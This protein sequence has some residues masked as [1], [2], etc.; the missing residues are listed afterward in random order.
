MQTERSAFFILHALLCSRKD[1]LFAERFSGRIRCTYRLHA[2]YNFI[3]C[4]IIFFLLF[5][6]KMKIITPPTVCKRCLCIEY[7]YLLDNSCS[8][9]SISSAEYKSRWSSRISCKSSVLVF[10]ISSTKSLDKGFCFELFLL[11][12]I[13]LFS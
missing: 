4:G 1:V 3:F 6:R 11:T 8:I 10:L 7:Y 5:Q 12:V 13:F 9:K 2:S